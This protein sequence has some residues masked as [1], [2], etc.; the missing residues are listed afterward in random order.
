VSADAAGRRGVAAVTAG[1]GGPAGTTVATGPANAVRASGSPTGPTD[2]TRARTTGPAVATGP[3]FTGSTPA[4]P[5][6]TAGTAD[7][8]VVA[9]TALTEAIVFR[10]GGAAAV[11]AD[12]ADP[13]GTAVTTGTAD[14]V[15]ANGRTTVTTKPTGA[16]RAG[17]TACRA[18]RS[19]GIGSR[20]AARTT[21][22]AGT[23]VTADPTVT[24]G[25]QGLTADPAGTAVT[26]RAA[27]I[28]SLAEASAV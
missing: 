5:T 21:G 4:D 9:R 22:P 2:T 14:P 10:T 7:P 6:V 28:Q 24:V 12:T 20:G 15:S 25:R 1:T 16:G 23:A 8:A 26:A 27:C 18:N 13:A 19:A 11:P 17:G 3:V